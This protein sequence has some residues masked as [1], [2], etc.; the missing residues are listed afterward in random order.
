M[1]EMQLH[2]GT[3]LCGAHATH[4]CQRAWGWQPQHAQ[5][6]GSEVALGSAA[7]HS[8]GGH[9]PWWQRSVVA[10]GCVALKTGTWGIS[11]GTPFQ[12]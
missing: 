8:V 7:V 2:I 12:C 3:W 9:T 11:S 10:A 6:G 1:A 4:G 5:R